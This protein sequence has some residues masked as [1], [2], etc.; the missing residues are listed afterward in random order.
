[1]S[2]LTYLVNAQ[3]DS[4]KQEF[5]AKTL[6]R[7]ILNISDGDNKTYSCD[8]DIGDGKILYNVPIANGSGDVMYAEVGSAVRVRRSAS[9]WYEITG[10]SKRM[11]G[12][13]IRVPVTIPKFDFNPM[14]RYNSPQPPAATGGTVIGTPVQIGPTSRP[15][16]YEELA[17]FGGYGTAPYGAVAIYMDGVFQEIR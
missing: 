3:I 4:K 9:G 8:V 16:T 1:M 5:D 6:T 2:V 12:T 14:V 15:L 17:T 7:P 11:P 13:N 10:F